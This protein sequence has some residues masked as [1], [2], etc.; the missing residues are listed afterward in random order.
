MCIFQQKNGGAGLTQRGTKVNVHVA[1]CSQLDESMKTVHVLDVTGF[2]VGGWVG[3][4]ARGH[5]GVWARAGGRVGCCRN[6]GLAQRFLRRP[7]RS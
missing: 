7:H 4:W 6:K 2:L 5:A 1:T 3:G